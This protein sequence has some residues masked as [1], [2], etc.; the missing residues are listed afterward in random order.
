MTSEQNPPDPR[1]HVAYV[2][3]CCGGTFTRYAETPAEADGV[4]AYPV[5]LECQHNFG[6]EPEGTC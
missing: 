3:R 1:I 6:P 2:C 4:R 5:C